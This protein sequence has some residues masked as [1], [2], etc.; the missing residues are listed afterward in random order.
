MVVA[1]PVVSNTNSK[2]RR[3]HNTAEPG[4]VAPTHPRLPPQPPK[5][6]GHGSP[7]NRSMKIER[8]CWSQRCDGSLVLSIA[9]VTAIMLIESLERHW[10]VEPGQ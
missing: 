7:L 4:A 10:V 2:K 1:E 9:G 6:W 8:V 5:V 3:G